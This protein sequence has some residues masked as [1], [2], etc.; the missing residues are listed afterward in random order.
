M[1]G[2]QIWR[3][4]LH[5]RAEIAR[6]HNRKYQAT[7]IAHL[8]RVVRRSDTLGIEGCV[9]M[10][11]VGINAL[12]RLD[13]TAVNQ[14]LCIGLKQFCYRYAKAAGTYYTYGSFHKWILDFRL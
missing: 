2:F 13:F 3:K 12:N 14:D 6:R 5:H 11:M 9:V 10:K 7:F 4:R 8:L 1:V